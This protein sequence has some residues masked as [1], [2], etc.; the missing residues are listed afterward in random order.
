MFH[1]TILQL[2]PPFSPEK[3]A[4]LC[5]RRG[6]PQCRMCVQPPGPGRVPA[7]LTSTLA[8]D[9]CPAQSQ[10]SSGPASNYFC[11]MYCFVH[12]PK[13][14]P[15]LS[16]YVKHSMCLEQFLWSRIV[17]V[18]LSS[19]CCLKKSLS[20]KKLF[21]ISVLS[22]PTSLRLCLVRAM[23]LLYVYLHTGL[24][25]PPWGRVWWGRWPS[26]APWPRVSA[27]P[28]P[29]GSAHSPASSTCNEEVCMW[30]LWSDGH[31]IYTYYTGSTHS[32]V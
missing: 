2:H 22:L 11:Y 16:H 14:T 28:P 10:A 1:Y 32:L 15:D 8:S 19:V 23:A 3:W 7:L 27:D 31:S 30:A 24:C 29:P 13:M 5:L 9:G 25:L 17:T 4:S 12:S 21:C 20:I 26:L 6:W 18:S